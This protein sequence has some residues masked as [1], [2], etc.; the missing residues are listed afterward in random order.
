MELNITPGIRLFFSFI[1]VGIFIVASKSAD[2]STCILCVLKL[3]KLIL[4]DYPTGYCLYEML[5]AGVKQH[6]D[7]IYTNMSLV[8]HRAVLVDF[9]VQFVYTEHHYSD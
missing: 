2:P 1:L 7:E 9:H 8:S 4:G 6:Y 5:L 3:Q